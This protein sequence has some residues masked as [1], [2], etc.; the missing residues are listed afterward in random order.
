MDHTIIHGH[1]KDA[2]GV[3]E[4]S[5][6]IIDAYVYFLHYCIKTNLMDIALPLLE[7]LSKIKYNT[8]DNTNI[9]HM[10]FK[11][12]RWHVISVICIMTRQQLDLGKKA[13]QLA[14]AAANKAQDKN[15]MVFFS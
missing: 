8:N 11:Y 13:C 4:T 9:N 1:F 5:N 2:I 10:F 7:P 15:N 12:E 3:H 6:T 14:I